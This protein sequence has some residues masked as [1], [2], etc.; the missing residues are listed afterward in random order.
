M[1]FTLREVRRGLARGRGMAPDR[2][3]SIDGRGLEHERG[4]VI[5]RGGGTVVAV[6]VARVTHELGHLLEHKPSR[7][8]RP[9]SDFAYLPQMPPTYAL[10]RFLLRMATLA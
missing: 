8:R 3:G 2:R 7:G 1:R 6:R 4:S 10:A 5:R 9:H